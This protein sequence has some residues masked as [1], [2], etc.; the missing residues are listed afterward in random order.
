[1][2][3]YVLKYARGEEVKY[4]SHLDFVRM[5]HR[6]VRRS[7]LEM[8]FSQ[9][10]NP[11]PLMTVA[12]PL[13]VG[14]TSDGEYMKIA[15]AQDY[16]EEHIAAKLNDALPKGF[17]ILRAKRVEGKELDLTKIDRADYIVIAELENERV[18]DIQA[19]LENEQ[20]NVMKK[21]KSGVKEADVR[22]YIYK[23]E[24]KEADG[25]LIMLSMRLA[26][27]S[28]YN[29]KPDTVLDAMEK[30]CGDIKIMF[31]SV[32]RAAMLCGDTEYL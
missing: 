30:Y 16:K 8:A 25:R 6:A 23:L 11:H 14:V 15:F 5:F 12:L 31:K 13:S 9:G 24:L 32:H 1:M 26:A 18:P 27:G 28:S 2:S 21:S 22:P 10:F 19:F 4:I 29:L 3:N 17:K 7:G 20:I